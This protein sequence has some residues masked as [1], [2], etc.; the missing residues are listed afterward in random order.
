MPT[1]SDKMIVFY[2]G[3]CGFCDRTVQYIIEKDRNDRFRFAPLQSDLAESTLPKHGKNPKDLN[4]LY[5]L[6]GQDESKEQVFEKSDAVI[7]I[8]E[9]LGGKAARQVAWFKWMPKWIRD[10][11][12][13]LFARFRYRVFGKKESCSLPTPE[14]RSK[15][16]GV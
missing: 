16:I 15:F 4:S 5:L 6:T 9:A 1:P 7:R 8:A 13:T 10:V 3:L 14:Q 2:D 11:G 12:Y